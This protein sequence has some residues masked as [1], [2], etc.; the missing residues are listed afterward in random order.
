MNLLRRQ[1]FD[2]DIDL[3]GFGV[4]RQAN[5]FHTVQQRT[6]NIH[7][8]S[9]AKEHHIGQVVVDLQIV[10]VEVVI[11][12]WVQH[13]KQR[14][15]RVTAHI[16]AHFVDFIEQE[17]RVTHAD[18]GHLLNQSTRHGANIGAAMT[19]DFS[20]ITHTTERHT[21]ELTVCGTGNRLGQ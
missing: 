7:R 5:H 2:R 19:T 6:R 13:L 3:L 9:R 1:V 18:F 4:T 21:H 16:L 11:L 8:V 17:Q 14:R 12:L 10:I 15:R 20:F